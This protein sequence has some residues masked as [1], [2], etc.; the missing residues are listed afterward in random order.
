MAC[1]V[2]VDDG[3]RWGLLGCLTGV[4]VDAGAHVAAGVEPGD[5]VAAG[6][7]VADGVE[8]GLGW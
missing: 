8:V 7:H 4:L 1:G 3:I 2:A 5:Q 6:L